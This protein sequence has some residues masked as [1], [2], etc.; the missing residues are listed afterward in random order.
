MRLVRGRAAT[1]DDDRA[2]TAAMLAR[3]GETGREAFRAWT[4]H[5]QV[6]FGRRDAHADGY[7]GARAAATAREYA[8]V[9]RSVGGRAVAYSGSTVAFAHAVPVADPRQGLTERYEAG[10][11]G[12]LVA[13]DGLG[14]GV[15]RGE[16][17][18]S[19]CPGDHSVRL[20]DGGKVA[21]IAQRVGADA[22][23][24]AGCVLVADRADLV[25]VLAAVY[26]ALGVPFDPASVG[27]VAAGGGPAA[28]RRTCRAL[29]RAFVGDPDD[30][31]VTVASVDAVLAE[32][33]GDPG[34]S[35][36]AGGASESGDP[37]EASES[38]DPG[39]VDE[40]SE[41]G[42]PGEASETSDARGAD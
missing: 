11:D 17:P 33:G 27:T 37:G 20:A 6:A 34:E 30:P 5:R 24:V 23:L 9:E 7:D 15:R 36:E 12:V 13:L 10:V 31:R 4:P 2:A 1:P 16:P 42:D 28:P 19:Y 38:G 26:D 40:A 18:D 22:A 21:G 14:V 32:A 8:V 41:S 35:G 3:A 29:E 25:D 39:E